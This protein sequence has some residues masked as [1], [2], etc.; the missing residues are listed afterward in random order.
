MKL[1]LVVVPL[2]FQWWF[3]SLLEWQL[4]SW[5]PVAAIP[6]SEDVVARPS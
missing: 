2:V 3:Y 5:L 1:I 6:Q 4:A